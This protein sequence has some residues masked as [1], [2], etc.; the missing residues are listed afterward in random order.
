MDRCPDRHRQQGVAG[1]V[2]RRR[3]GAHRQ[4]DPRARARIVALTRTR[5]PWSARTIAAYLR[6]TDGMSPVR[7]GA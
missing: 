5:Q 6:R 3:G 4:V 7:R 2:G 1:L